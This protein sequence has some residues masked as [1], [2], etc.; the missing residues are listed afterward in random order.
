[1]TPPAFGSAPGAPFPGVGFTP[2]FSKEQELEMLKEQADM[3][4]QQMEQINQRISE[5]EQ[6]SSEPSESSE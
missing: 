2:E 3:L 6:E 5:L 4:N 1:M